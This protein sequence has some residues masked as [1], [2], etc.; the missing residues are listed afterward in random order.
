MASA[1]GSFFGEGRFDFHPDNA[2]G[3]CGS[4]QKCCRSGGPILAF[5]RSAGEV[6]R[7]FPCDSAWV[8]RQGKPRRGAEGES[9]L[10]A[11]VVEESYPSS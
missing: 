1:F 8:L 10:L 11:G 3:L 6:L 7:G 2:L 5:P 9:G 4:P